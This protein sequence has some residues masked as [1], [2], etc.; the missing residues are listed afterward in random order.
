MVCCVLLMLS[1]A[2]HPQGDPIDTPQSAQNVLSTTQPLVR[3]SPTASSTPMP[4]ASKT[5]TST[6]TPLATRPVR[7]TS[8]PI[9]YT[10]EAINVRS[11]AGTDFDRIGALP[12]GAAIEVIGEKAG[13]YQIKFADGTGWVFGEYT[14][15]TRPA[16]P[17]STRP[18]NSPATL[19]VSTPALICPS[20][21]QQITSCE[22]A[23]ACLQAGSTSFDRDHDGVPCENICPGG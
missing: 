20:T 5:I 15:L 4:T 17:H 23:Y 1:A 16:A 18:A 9:R 21:C 8:V 2:K 3:S 22:Q 6:S 19:N 10:T 14:T 12:A 7:N 11:G 13:W